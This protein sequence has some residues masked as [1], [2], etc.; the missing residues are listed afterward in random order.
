MMTDY[1]VLP[2]E[3]ARRR[4][5]R[6]FQEFL[7]LKFPIYAEHHLKIRTKNEGIKPFKLNDGQLKLLEHTEAQMQ[8]RGY[9]R[10]LLLKA[11]QWGGSTLIQGMAYRNVTTI[12]GYKA[13]IMS[14]RRDTT[15][16]LFG[17]TK[18]FNDE[19][20][21]AYRAYSPS[22]GS[23]TELKFPKLDSMYTVGT[24]GSK[25][26]GHGETIQFLHASEFALWP[27]AN[28]HLNGI[29][30]TV[31]ASGLGTSIYIESTGK[32]MGN[33][34][35][36]L[37]QE[38]R[39]MMGDYWF[40]FVPW[41][42]FPE[43]GMPVSDDLILTPQEE[44]FQRVYGLSDEQMSFRAFKILEMGGGDIGE[45]KF[46]SQ[47]PTTP[48]D[49]FRTP[50]VGSYFDATYV[51]RARKTRIEVPYGS[52]IMGIDPS[53]VGSDRFSVCMRQGRKAYHIGKWQGK[54]TDESLGLVVRLIRIHQPEYIFVDQGGPGA[55]IVDLLMQMSRDGLINCTVIP[56]DF[57]GSPDDD[58]RYNIKREEMYGRAKEWL[59]QSL[60]VQIDDSDELQA[61]LTN[62]QF[63]YDN[64][65]RVQPESKQ[66]MCKPPRSLPSPD[67]L[68][69]FVLT[70]AFFVKAKDPEQQMVGRNDIDPDRPINW[71]AV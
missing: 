57:G 21:S 69:S 51:T 46:C 65:G 55:G 44:L 38:A 39:K 58:D 19:M 4:K 22:G 13:F 7:D 54:R 12:R 9:V 52:K 66:T 24:A 28:D 56:V 2:G 18:R 11:R 25:T 32:G 47:Y 17:M 23:A 8:V 27:N 36:R 64:A 35:H 33:E 68:E 48:E 10:T 60:P 1:S 53:H 5:L 14:H 42:L 61:D 71:R 45:A 34:F 41:F 49:A 62:P 63:R 26:V 67:L 59:E 43:Y 20:G 6:E 15:A 16:A 37:V 29:F 50:V 30:Q 3:H 31:P 40:L 70:F